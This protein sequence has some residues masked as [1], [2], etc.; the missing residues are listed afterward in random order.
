MM[1]SRYEASQ[2]VALGPLTQE[3]ESDVR[4]CHGSVLQH[5]G[6]LGWPHVA[7]NWEGKVSVPRPPLSF[8]FPLSAQ[9]V[10]STRGLFELF[11]SCPG[12]TVSASRLLINA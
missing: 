11:F 12:L 4:C 6:V 7:T 9:T 5:P 10:E 3:G 8:L 2:R 1:L